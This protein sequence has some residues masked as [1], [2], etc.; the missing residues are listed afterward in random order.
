MIENILTQ[1]ESALAAVSRYTLGKDF[2]AYC[3]LRTVI[4]LTQ[5]DKMLRPALQAPYVFVT[6]TGD[7]ASVFEI[8]GA[9]CE[10]DEKDTFN[11]RAQKEDPESFR[12]YIAKRFNF[13]Y[14]IK[15]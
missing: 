7:Y 2:T 5:E 3:D 15:N 9:F 6:H 14:N 13:S 8:Q 4:G 11:E 1:I 12:D 10:F